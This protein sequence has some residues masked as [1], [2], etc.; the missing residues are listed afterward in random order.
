ETVRSHG[1]GTGVA[2]VLPAALAPAM[3]LAVDPWGWYPF[4]PL[5][6]LVT[7][8]LVLCSTAVVLARP[9][10]ERGGRLPPTVGWA[11]VLLVAAMGVAAAF[12]VDDLFA[13]TGT[14]E[15]HGGFVLWALCVLALAVGG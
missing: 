5:R 14:P 9:A 4:G 13:W 2:H 12:G 8:T 15:R 6:W 10:G 3:V 11:A 7:S 1:M